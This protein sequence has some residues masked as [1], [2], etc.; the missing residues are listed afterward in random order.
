MFVNF[1]H[2][3]TKYVNKETIS[4][5]NESSLSINGRVFMDVKQICTHN[6]TQNE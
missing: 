4:M 5:V 1:C 3:L 2:F 6:Q